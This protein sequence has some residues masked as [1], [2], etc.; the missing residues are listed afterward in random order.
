MKQTINYKTEGVCSRQ[1]NLTVEDGVIT[2]AAFVGGCHGNTQGVA[3]LVIGMEAKEAIRR[4]R[5]I[6]CGFKPTSCPD[7]LAQALEK[8]LQD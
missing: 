7:Q 8:N 6:K 5:G 1:I 2:E 3:A 4:L